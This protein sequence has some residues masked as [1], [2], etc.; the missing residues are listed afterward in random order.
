MNIIASIQA[1][2]GSTRLPGKVLKPILGKPMLQWHIERIRLSRLID[3]VVVATTI[4][5]KDDEIV[6][7]CE[8]IGVKYYRGSENDVLQRVTDLVQNFKA[9][10]H[11]ECFGDSP[12]TDPQIIDEFIGYLLKHSEV[13]FVSNSIETTYPPGAEV[14][15]YRSKVL[16][17]ANSK[18]DA[19]DPLREH[20]SLHI[21]NRTESYNVVNLSA[22][23]IYHFPDLYF[24]VDTEQDFIVMNSIIISLSKLYGIG[25]PLI[26]IIDFLKQHPEIVKLNQDIPRRWKEFRKDE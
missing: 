14:L 6:E 25:F 22:P 19:S 1:R 11:V 24:E 16:V 12:L 4:S 9:D 21:Y 23:D 7:F 15:A 17:D 5:S 3:D 8:S 26:T 2:M 20:V 13:D 10:I 18:T